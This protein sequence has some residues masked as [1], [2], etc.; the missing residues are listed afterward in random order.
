MKLNKTQFVIGCWMVW[1]GAALGSLVVTTGNSVPFSP[2]ANNLAHGILPTS[3]VNISA[4]AEGAKTPRV[5]TDGAML[6]KA[7]TNCYTIGNAAVLEYD[8][9]DAPWG[10]DVAGLNFYTWWDNRDNIFIA[11]IAFEKTSRPDVWM[12][13]PGAA[14]NYAS[15]GLVYAKYTDSTGLM[16]DNVK[17]VRITFGTPQENNYAGYGEIEITGALSAST[18]GC[19]PGP[20]FVVGEVMGGSTAFTGS[21]GVSAV[22]FPIPAG[23]D[24]WMVTTSAV[25][26][27]VEGGTWRAVAPAPAELTFERPAS[28]ADVVLHS[29]FTNSSESVSLLRGKSQTF[30]YTEAAPTALARTSYSRG[31]PA[32]ED[33]VIEPWHLDTGSTAG[34]S[35]GD[36]IATLPMNVTWR[37][38]GVVSGPGADADA[39]AETATLAVAGDY[40][41]RLTVRNDAGNEAHADV[42]VAIAEFAAGAYVWTGGA[43]SDWLNPLNWNNNAIPRDGDDIE[44][45]AGL[46]RY[47]TIQAGTYPATGAY[48]VLDV[49]AGARITCKGDPT[50]INEASGGTASSPHGLGVALNCATAL[51]AGT[52]TADGLGFPARTGPLGNGEGAGHGGVNFSDYFGYDDG[53]AYGS[54]TQP[55]SL[56]SGGN[57]GIGQ[58]GGGA[59]K[60]NASGE[61]AVN[62]AVTAKGLSRGAGG[63]IWIVCNTLSGTGLVDATANNGGQGAGAGRISLDY[64]SSTFTGNVT[65]RGSDGAYSEGSDGTLWEPKRFDALIGAPGAPVDVVVGNSYSYLFAD[66]T[67]RYWN[68]TIAD[69]AH[70]EF[71]GGRLMI[72]SLK[73]GVNSRLRFDKWF[74]ESPA[75]MAS[76][77]FGSVEVAQGGRLCLPSV[78]AVPSYDIGSLYIGTNASVHV[79]WGDQLAINEASGGTSGARHGAGTTLRC[80]SATVFGTLSAQGRGFGNKTGPVYSTEGNAHGGRCD[81]NMGYGVIARPTSLGAGIPAAVYAGGGALKL[82]VGGALRLDGT[83]TSDPGQVSNGGRNAGGSVWIQAGSLIGAGLVTARGGTDGRPGAA[84]RIAVESLDA[85]GFTGQVKV[86]GRFGQLNNKSYPG[87][88]FRADL[89]HPAAFAADGGV[90]LDTRYSKT[91]SDGTIFPEYVTNSTNFDIEDAIVVARTVTR[92]NPVANRYAWTE[93]C[94]KKST[95]AYIANT[96]NNTI[97]G[98]PP[99][100][101]FMVKHNGEYL[102]GLASRD[103]TV[104]GVLSFSVP[105]DAQEHSIEVASWASLGAMVI[106]R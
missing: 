4:N 69:G 20:D 39:L 89:V 48:G 5:L 77:S 73:V 34:T 78:A 58:G 99:S 26:A 13:V 37:G 46:A 41:L 85:T 52:L 74:P 81:Y 16:A 65:A 103:S 44:I 54:A 66:D 23:Y 104:D 33:V 98:L 97:T 76:L 56:G 14:L 40:V 10:Y 15:F 49:K 106:V 28:D 27:A 22:E 70:V 3:V 71:H 38:V 80:A 8:L 45:P 31:L 95:G 79:G 55:T 75:D 11:E 9:G 82:V 59:I 62:G 36:G 50:A 43:D 18:P 29:W 102:D 93:S 86:T 25:P 96:A 35:S 101:S 30:R 42:P 63:S 88:I 6:A 61:V 72:G 19:L 87:T 91:V 53:R 7:G 24:S 12:P 92:W 47:P 84:G 105:L 90:D 2:A 100:T 51:V 32:G 68:L 57:G 64:A 17:S 21:N 83:I 1:A 60:I 94:T 67:M